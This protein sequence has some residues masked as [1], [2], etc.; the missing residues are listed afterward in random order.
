MN[1]QYVFGD[2]PEA[3]VY[4]VDRSHDNVSYVNAAGYV[5]AVGY[6]DEV[7]HM[8]ADGN[9]YVYDVENSV[10]FAMDLRAHD[11]PLC[12]G[13]TGL[14]VG[15]ILFRRDHSKMGSSPPD[16][17]FGR[18]LPALIRAVPYAIRSAVNDGFTASRGSQVAQPP[19]DFSAGTP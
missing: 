12:D 6:A 5:Y 3:H 11:W 7:V 8:Y 17:S 10:H 16:S 13:T 19:G 4:V 9:V 14:R 1:V 18:A 2:N 15:S